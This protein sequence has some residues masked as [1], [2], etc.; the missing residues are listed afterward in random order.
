MTRG[1]RQLPK[2]VGDRLMKPLEAMRPHAIFCDSLEVFGS[3]WTGDLLE[4]F[5]QRRGYDLRP[6][7]PALATDIAPNTKAI[8]HDWGKTLTEM[9]EDRFLT[10]M[11]NGR[12]TTASNSAYRI[13]DSARGCFELQ[14]R[15][16]SGRRGDAVE[17]SAG[18]A[19]RIVGKSPAEPVDHDIRDMDAAALARIKGYST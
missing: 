12:S 10:P 8:R 15:G 13:R 3:D 17:G 7:L 19:V 18:F 9:L 2:N 16:H 1:D 14:V 11:R 5:R 6:Y 4:Q